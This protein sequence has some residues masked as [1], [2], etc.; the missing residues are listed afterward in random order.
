MSRR[1]VNP[2]HPSLFARFDAV[3]ATPSAPPSAVRVG[4]RKKGR[5]AV[6]T[7]F[8]ESQRPDKAVLLEGVRSILIDRLD[9]GMLAL[10]DVCEGEFGIVDDLFLNLVQ[11]LQE[12]WFPEAWDVDL[13]A[14]GRKGLIP[15][16]GVGKVPLDGWIALGEA[17]RG[18]KAGAA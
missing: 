9:A 15:R 13:E 14:E 4:K 1:Y 16:N 8:N 3:T 17:M 18:V 2:Y 12:F 10:R 6:K 11:R 7:K 5:R